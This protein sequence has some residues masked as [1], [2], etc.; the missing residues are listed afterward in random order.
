MGFLGFGDKN[1]MDC[2][3]DEQGNLVCRK[4]K[5][6]KDNK[7]ATGSEATISIDP[8]TCEANFI[9]RYSVL[10]EDEEDFQR[11]AKKRAIACKKGLL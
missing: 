4:F 10:E 1:G 5:A 8:K 7:L 2:E 6:G 11:I 9:G 3:P